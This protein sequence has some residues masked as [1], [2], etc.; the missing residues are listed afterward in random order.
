MSPAA[1]IK[2]DGRQEPFAAGR[3]AAAIARA[4]AA[5]G[6][7]DPGTAEELARVAAEHLT[8]LD[9][10]AVP[11]EAVQD[12]CVHVLQE[13]GHYEAAVAFVR[14]RDARERARR[15]RIADGDRRQAANLHVVDGQWRSRPWD[16][17]WLAGLVRARTGLGERAAADVV[18]QAERLLAGTCVDQLPLHQVMALAHAAMVQLGLHAAGAVTAPIG[19]D[20]G[21]IRRALLAPGDGDGLERLGRAMARE[22]SLSAL[23]LPGPALRLW[24]QGR[25]W[26]SGIDDPARGARLTTTVE[27][28]PNPWQVLTSAF[29]LCQ[30]AATHWQRVRLV[31][32]PA[33]LGHLERGASALVAPIAALARSAEVFLYCDG[34]TPLLSSWPFAGARVGLASYNQD[35]I[36]DQRMRE[37]GRSLLSGPTLLDPARPQRVLADLAVNAQGLDRDLDALDEL[38]LAA[39]G[40]LHARLRLLGALGGEPVAAGAARSAV[41]GLPH[42]SEARRYLEDQ[43]VQEARRRAMVLERAGSLSEE[44]CA[45]FGRLL[46]DPPT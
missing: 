28:V 4:L 22:W 35:F 40:A 3:I 33:V 30:S 45:H 13:S 2:R 20:P 29:A 41:Y 21:E 31:L 12:A 23:H 19:I 43:I 27:S 17:A 38:A 16:A 5:V 36:L 14:Y 24:S 7:D 8:R 44:A 37:F 11:L 9:D 39:V 18:A 46:D 34:R 15:E 42:D 25:L 10:A 1:I 26:V 6:Q 32:P